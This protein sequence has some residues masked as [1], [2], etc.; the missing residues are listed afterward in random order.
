MD[1]LD[2]NSS[3]RCEH[4]TH[5]GDNGTLAAI[6]QCHSQCHSANAEN[7]KCNANAQNKTELVRGFVSTPDFAFDIVSSKV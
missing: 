5:F 3:G 6:S 2:Y 4:F 7:K 1:R